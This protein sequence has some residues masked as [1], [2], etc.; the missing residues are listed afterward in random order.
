MF[1]NKSLTTKNNIRSFELRIIANKKLQMIEI[2]KL[3]LNNQS[4]RQ[5]ITYVNYEVTSVR[6]RIPFTI[7]HIF[8]TIASIV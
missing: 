5:K 8:V 3:I 7:K 1:E 6:V 4:G 2:E